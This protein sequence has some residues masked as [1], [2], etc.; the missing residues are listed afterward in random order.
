MSVK[1]VCRAS[2]RGFFDCLL[3]WTRPGKLRSRRSPQPS[4]PRRSTSITATLKT[5]V[6]ADF[7]ERHLSAQSKLE[8]CSEVCPPEAPYAPESAPVKRFVVTLRVRALSDQ[9]S[10]HDETHHR[11]K[12]DSHN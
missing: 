12:R 1:R 10:K 8:I 2:Y 9:N 11:P 5:P 4:A 3:A 7:K 6:I